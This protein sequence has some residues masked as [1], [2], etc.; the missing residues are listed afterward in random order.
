MEPGAVAGDADVDVA[1]M[2]GIPALD[3]RQ[4][5][6]PLAGRLQ[7]RQ[8]PDRKSGGSSRAMERFMPLPYYK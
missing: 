1:A 6:V 8:A 5:G 7:R 2:G 3:R 4:A